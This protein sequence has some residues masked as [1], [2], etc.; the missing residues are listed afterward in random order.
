MLWIEWIRPWQ[1]TPAHDH[2]ARSVFLRVI[3]ANCGS[4]PPSRASTSALS[5]EMRASNPSLTRDDL[6]VT[7]VSPVAF[8]ISALS[9]SS[10]IFTGNIPVLRVQVCPSIVHG[11]LLVKKP[12]VPES[13]LPAT[14]RQPTM[15]ESRRGR[16]LSICR[17]KEVR[18][19]RCCED[20]SSEGLASS[21]GLLL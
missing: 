9:M 12:H 4:V 17:W 6:S 7:P 20:A 10:V 14:C 2:D 19:G 5:A 11:L 8:S 15:D 18:V 13:A 16:D 1:R 3:I 21:R